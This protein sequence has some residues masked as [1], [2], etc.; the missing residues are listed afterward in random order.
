MV[1][2]VG[3]HKVHVSKTQDIAICTTLLL[4]PEYGTGIPAG[5]VAW[6]HIMIQFRTRE[7]PVARRLARIYAM[8]DRFLHHRPACGG[9]VPESI[10]HIMREC[11]RW[12]C[13]RRIFGTLAPYLNGFV[14]Q[15]AT[16]LED[17]NGL[18]LGGVLPSLHGAINFTGNGRFFRLWRQALPHI[19]FF[20][21]GVSDSRNVLLR[22]MAL[23]LLALL[24]WADARTGRANLSWS[25]PGMHSCFFACH[26]KVLVGET[27]TRASCG[28][29]AARYG[30]LTVVRNALT[31]ASP[32]REHDR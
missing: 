6:L 30:S 15:C 17:I 25:V 13:H 29:S 5:A 22:D 8:P 32:S 18:L 27:P 16:S 19:A 2:G 9:D 11:P 20:V 12:E 28:V 10:E 26:R 4:P 14:R 23:L 1:W 24:E 3:L 31:R 7:F 21:V